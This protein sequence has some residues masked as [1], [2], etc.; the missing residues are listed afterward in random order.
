MVVG[1]VVMLVGVVVSVS[2]V[3]MVVVARF[4]LTA[5]WRRG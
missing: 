3:V 2:T 1:A 4:L 5:R